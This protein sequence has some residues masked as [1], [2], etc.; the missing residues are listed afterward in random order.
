MIRHRLKKKGTVSKRA[1]RRYTLMLTIKFLIGAFSIPACAQTSA[2]RGWLVLEAGLAQKNAAQRVAAVRVLGLIPDDAHAAEL[3]EKGL[4]DKSSAVRVAAATSLGKMHATEADA[5]LREA[6]NDKNL[7]V[8]MA[9]AHAL[10]LLNDPTCYDV[11]Y[12]VFTGERKNN[13]GMIA[14]EM[15]VLHDPKQLAQMGFSEGI[16]YV[17]LAGIGWEA[18][19]M[20]MKDKKSGAAAKAALISALATD[21]EP[22]TG[23]LLLKVSNNPNWVLRVA[24]LEAI[25]RR[26]DPA[27]RSGIEL[28]LSDS[29]HEVRFAAAATV[30]HLN[31]LAEAQ[32]AANTKTARAMPSAEAVQTQSET[33]NASDLA[34]SLFRVRGSFR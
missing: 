17:P 28:R 6:L 16:G 21:P 30:I 15:Q 4:K 7:P 5:S 14:Q 29:K 27:L 9:A 23:K 11:Y 31:D 22:R 26:G 24:A 2:D 25:D 10:R 20:I 34:S 8:V 13:S 33:D 1:I 18:F 32:A 3:A 19:Q 12:E